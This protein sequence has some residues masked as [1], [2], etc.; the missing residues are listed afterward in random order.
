MTSILHFGA[1]QFI[2]TAQ[3]AHYMFRLPR[4]SSDIAILII[5]DGNRGNSQAC[6]WFRSHAAMCENN[7]AAVQV[8]HATQ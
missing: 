8:S 7:S 4:G 1:A 6:N 2:L 5:M 3:A